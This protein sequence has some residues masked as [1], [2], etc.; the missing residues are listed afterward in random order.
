MRLPRPVIESAKLWA[1]R[2]WIA[3]IVV[4]VAVYLIREWPRIEIG[5]ARLGPAS[6]LAALA[7]VALA[8]LTLT[9]VAQVSCRRFGIDISLRESFYL[10]NFTQIAKYI[11]GSIWQFVGRA[12][13]LKTQGVEGRKIR[14]AMIYEIVWVTVSAGVLGLLFVSANYRVFLDRMIEI[15]WL[16]QSAPRPAILVVAGV[17]LT[18]ALGLF[19]WLLR[20]RLASGIAALRPTP[21][22]VLL[23]VITWFA[24]GLS[25]WVTSPPFAAG[26]IPILYTIGVYCLGYTIG[27]V[28]PFA[29]AGIG[30]REVIFTLGMSPYLALPDAVLLAGINRIVYI[31]IELLFFAIAIF[32]R[33]TA[34]PQ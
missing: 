18:L 4:F 20:R 15:D 27:F 7:L 31:A 13:L 29:P 19:V 25:L 6:I 24:L 32:S 22:L 14:N 8:K 2:L 21:V 30:I 3:A 10:Y 12:A 34:L 16:P 28:V 9:I 17:A 26:G 11:P 33:R 5:L 23:L 1:K